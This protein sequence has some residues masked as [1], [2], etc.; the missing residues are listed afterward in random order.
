[1]LRGIFDQANDY[2]SSWNSFAQEL[3]NT[4]AFIRSHPE[5][6]SFGM[7]REIGKGGILLTVAIVCIVINSLTYGHLW[8]IRREGNSVFRMR[9]YVVLR[10]AT[11]VLPIIFAEL[12]VALIADAKARLTDVE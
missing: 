4:R 1:M 6:A 7:T 8:R 9:D 5:Y 12:R 11:K 2:S 3:V 10:Q